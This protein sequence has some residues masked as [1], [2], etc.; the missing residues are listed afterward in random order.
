MSNEQLAL[1]ENQLLQKTAV[2]GIQAMEEGL[3]CGSFVEMGPSKSQNNLYGVVK[4]IG[5]FLGP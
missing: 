1:F 2:W 5:P 4:M 3:T